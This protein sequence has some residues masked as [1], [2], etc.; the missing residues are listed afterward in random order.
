[1]QSPTLRDNS[2]DQDKQCCKGGA[3]AQCS[4]SGSRYT[5][6]MLAQAS[7]RL[8][9]LQGGLLAGACSSV[10]QAGQLCSSCHYGVDEISLVIVGNAL[11][12]LQGHL[13]DQQCEICRCSVGTDLSMIHV[14]ST[15]ST[16]QHSHRWQR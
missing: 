6:H 13:Q 8:R 2:A 7:P 9:H 1:M 12:Y 4:F 11:E 3:R 14:D 5:V 10:V 16:R 15:A